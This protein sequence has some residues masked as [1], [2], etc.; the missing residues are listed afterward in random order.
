MF[1]LSGVK[2]AVLCSYEVALCSLR[3]LHQTITIWAQNFTS[4]C[5]RFYIYLHTSLL[6]A[7]A[8]RQ[9]AENALLGTLPFPSMSD[10]QGQ[11]V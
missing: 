5:N 3:S 2:K 6:H 10:P 1:R 4:S 7:Y 11:G 9:K 8:H